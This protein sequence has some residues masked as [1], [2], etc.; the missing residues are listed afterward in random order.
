[1]ILSKLKKNQFFWNLIDKASFLYPLFLFKKIPNEILIETTNACNLR[2]PVCPTHFAM[3]REKGFMKFELF[4]SIIDEFKNL[5][6]KPRIMMIFAGEP[7][8]NREVAKFISYA[9]DNGH[10]TFISTNAVLLNKELSK[11]LINAGLDSIH[12][13]IDGANKKSH[14]AYRIG[15]N[16]ESVKQ[17][18]EDFLSIKKELNKNNPIVAIQ[19]LLTSYSENEVDEI[20]EWCRKIGADQ[21]NFKSLSMGSF[22]SEEMKEKYNYLLPTKKEYKRKQS[23]I[24]KTICRTPNNQAVVFWN[25]DLGL[26]CIDFDSTANLPNIKENGFIKTFT[27]K[28]VRKKRKFG[29]Q[30][31]YGLCKKCSLGNADFMGLNIN[32]KK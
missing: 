6:V 8:L 12:L 14:E 2:C 20:T 21:V 17:N 15:S 22:T 18:I 7:T 5:E 4:Q 24:Y 19:V 30:K 32:L 10:K 16:F 31:K 27:S 11:N 9:S 3:K 25:G 29:F 23:T 26:C 28:D 1:M 13:C